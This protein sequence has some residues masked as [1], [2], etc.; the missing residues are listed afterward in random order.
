MR[1]DG[2]SMTQRLPEETKTYFSDR[3]LG[4]IPQAIEEID[5]I[6]WGGFRA[7][8]QARIDDGSFGGVFPSMC[9]DGQ[10]P[11]GTNRRNFED[12]MRAEIRSIPEEPWRNSLDGP[13]D[14]IVILDMLE[15]GWWHVAEPEKE[16][17]HDF[18][19]HYHL[20]FDY[21]MGRNE[22]AGDVNRIFRRNGLAYTLTNE[23][24]IERLGPLVLREELIS[25]HFQSGDNILDGLLEDARRKFLSPRQEIRGEA[26]EK[27]WDAWERLKTTGEGSGK[28][29]QITSL[30]DAAAGPNSPQFRHHLEKDARKLTDIGNDLH[31]RHFEMDKEE[32]QKSEHIDYLFHRLFNMVQLILR[33][34]GT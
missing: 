34:K 22:F 19:R 32:I 4:E 12:A 25:T 7:L 8:L 2:L 30:L 16:D 6:A 33:T 31:I 5:E 1:D 27:L 24:L 11:V 23:G 21:V 10:G 3:K 17:Y 26:L 29:E 15:F 18:F 9:P 14:T 28:K 20:S 13:P